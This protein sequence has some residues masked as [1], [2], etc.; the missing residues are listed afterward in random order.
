M[1]KIWLPRQ[2]ITF[3]RRGALLVTIFKFVSERHFYASEQ[4]IL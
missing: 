4:G 1:Y 3:F 2:F